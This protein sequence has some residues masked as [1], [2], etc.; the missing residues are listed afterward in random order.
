MAKKFK[1]GDCV[2]QHDINEA[3]E[4]FWSTGWRI[5]KDL[6]RNH[7]RILYAK[8]SRLDGTVTWGSAKD[9]RKSRQCRRTISE[10]RAKRRK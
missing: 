8:G 10:A 3:G 6:G 7:Y 4:R 5:D 2:D 1:V 9:L